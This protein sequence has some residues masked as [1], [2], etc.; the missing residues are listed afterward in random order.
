MPLFMDRHYI[1]NATKNA[2]SSAHQMDIAIQDEYGVN[3]MTYW[4][5]EERS[6]AFCLVEAPSEDLVRTVHSHA[7][8]EIP[9]EIIEVDPSI[10]QAFLGRIKDPPPLDKEGPDKNTS[11][12]DSAFRTIMFT[13]L[14]D[15][16]ATTNRLGD[17]KA[18]EMLRINNAITRNALRE[19]Q[20]TEVK[21]TG[22]G[23]MISFVSADNAVLCAKTIQKAFKVY[24]EKNTNEKMYLRIGLSAGEPVHEDGDLFGATV[25]LAARI[26]AYA[27]PEHTFLSKN[28][29][30]HCANSTLKFKSKGEVSLQGFQKPVSIFQ[31]FDH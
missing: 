16:T 21:H 10:V 1:E 23:L 31:L 5:D 27:D 11:Q 18:M 29:V 20:G 9:H 4:F 22:D 19:N 26:C 6:T 17:K 12:I 3:F 14:K 13:D 25:Q 2:L 24:N 7:H 8:G 28:V 15:S 30:D